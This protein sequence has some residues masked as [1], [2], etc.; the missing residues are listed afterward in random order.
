LVC[1]SN[2]KRRKNHQKARYQ[3]CTLSLSSE[4]IDVYKLPPIAA[5]SD[6]YYWPPCILTLEVNLDDL[7]DETASTV[8]YYWN[9]TD[10]GTLI[11]D[12]HVTCQR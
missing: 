3:H 1:L 10:C 8:A 11:F 12:A 7:R 2:K 4:E 5:L 6:K 9:L